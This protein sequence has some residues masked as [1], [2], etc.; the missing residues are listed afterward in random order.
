[1]ERITIEIDLRGKVNVLGVR[2]SGEVDAVSAPELRRILGGTTDGD[3][4]VSVVVDLAGVTAID[5]E[6][7]AALVAAHQQINGDG[8]AMQVINP[9]PAATAALR[10]AGVADLVAVTHAS[11]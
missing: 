6:G 10:A 11:G 1:V 9:S 4:I 3:G 5:A 2:V 7:V 8:A